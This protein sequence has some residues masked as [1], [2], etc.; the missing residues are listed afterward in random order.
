MVLIVALNEFRIL[1]VFFSTVGL[2]QLIYNLINRNLE[3]VPPLQNL[4]NFLF[5]FL[6]LLIFA[7]VRKVVCELEKTFSQGLLLAIF[8]DGQL[9]LHNLEANFILAK[10]FDDSLQ[11]SAQP[12]FLLPF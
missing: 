8:P 11:K 1:L 7:F 10:Q 3:L 2:N 4:G 12:S 6:L 9:L 5:E